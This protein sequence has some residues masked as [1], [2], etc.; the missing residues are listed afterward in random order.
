MLTISV[1]DQQVVVVGQCLPGSLLWRGLVEEEA[2]TAFVV[3]SLCGE[4]GI[5]L[6]FSERHFHSWIKLRSK[7]AGKLT[8]PLSIRSQNSNP[9]LSDSKAYWFPLCWFSFLFLFY[10]RNEYLVL[11]HCIIKCVYLFRKLLL[12]KET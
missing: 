4:C 6:P 7:K 2:W 5:S 3:S 8:T 9:G 10:R 1:C 11:K 12:L